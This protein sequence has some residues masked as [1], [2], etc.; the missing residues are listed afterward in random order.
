MKSNKSGISDAYQRIAHRHWVD[1][2]ECFG[3]NADL[4]MWKIATGRIKIITYRDQ[5]RMRAEVASHS[6]FE[7]TLLKRI[8]YS[9]S[10]PALKAR[11][12]LAM[13]SIEEK[14]PV[15]Y[16]TLVYGLGMPEPMKVSMA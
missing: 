2:L 1:E 8:Q 6:C 14:I 4:D 3:C 5:E 7:P 15:L 13:F 11:Y 9:L 16:D 12:K 10:A